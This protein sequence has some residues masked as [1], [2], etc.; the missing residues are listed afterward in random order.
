MWLGF[1]SP[2]NLHILL[3]SSK[4]AKTRVQTPGTRYFQEAVDFTLVRGF[5]RWGFW[6]VKQ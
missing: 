2:D 3:A 4:R 1:H 5:P 6:R